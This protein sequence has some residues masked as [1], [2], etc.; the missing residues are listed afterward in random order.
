MQQP[1]VTHG[2]YLDYYS[3]W[4]EALRKA[5]HYH[6]MKAVFEAST[7]FLGIVAELKDADKIKIELANSYSIE[8][9]KHTEEKFTIF[10]N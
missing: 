9:R 6:D 7:R 10:L 1:K 5:K 8:V 3:D 4:V 2:H